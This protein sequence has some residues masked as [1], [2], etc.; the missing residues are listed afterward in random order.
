MTKIYSYLDIEYEYYIYIYIYIYTTL[1]FGL[2]WF[3]GRSTMVA[4]LMTNPLYTYTL[5][6]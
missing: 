1:W 3:H 2:V 6:I 4:Y 5:D